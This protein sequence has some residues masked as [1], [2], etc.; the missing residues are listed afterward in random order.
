M[1]KPEEPQ[2]FLHGMATLPIH[3]KTDKPLTTVQCIN[4]LFDPDVVVCNRIPFDINCNSVYVVDMSNLAHPRDVVCDDM[5][6][7]R[8]KGSYRMWLSVDEVGCVEVLGKKQP[9]S[10]SLDHYR[11]WKRY[12]ENKSSKDLSKMIVTLEGEFY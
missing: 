11:I 2:F 1:S 8:W 6:V 4:I 10:M 9:E 7:W 5:G 3:T 12:Y